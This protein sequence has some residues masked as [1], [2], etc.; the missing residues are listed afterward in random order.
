MVDGNFKIFM[1]EM[2]TNVVNRQKSDFPR[3]KYEN[4]NSSLKPLLPCHL[5]E[6]LPARQNPLENRDFS[7]K[8]REKWHYVMPWRIET[9]VN[10]VSFKHPNFLFPSQKNT[11]LAW[12]EIFLT[13]LQIN[14]KSSLPR[15][16]L[17]EFL[18][19]MRFT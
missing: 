18:T 7:P 17:N 15:E 6:W 8:F 1:S 3:Q 19:Q 11:L 14:C 2:P 16:S 12:D 4:S 5:E 13:F 9:F 10:N